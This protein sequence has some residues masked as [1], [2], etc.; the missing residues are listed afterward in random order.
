MPRRSQFL[1]CDSDITLREKSVQVANA[2]RLHDLTRRDRA[3]K[4]WL[5]KSPRLI[6]M[7]EAKD[8]RPTFDF[9]KARIF[10]R[11]VSKKGRRNC[12]L[13]P[14]DNLQQLA[15][16]S[17]WLRENHRK[18]IPPNVW[19]GTKVTCPNE[20][21]RLDQLAR[22]G[23]DDTVRFAVLESLE[24][25]DRLDERLRRLDWLIYRRSSTDEGQLQTEVVKSLINRCRAAGVAFFLDRLGTNLIEDDD[26]LVLKDVTGSDW[27]QWPPYL[28][29]R[30][31]PEPSERPFQE[32]T[33]R[34]K[35]KSSRTAI[36]P[37]RKDVKPSAIKIEA[38][39]TIEKTSSEAAKPTTNTQAPTL[40]NG[41]F[42]LLSD[43]KKKET[44]WLWPQRIPL[45]ELTIIEGDPGTNKSSLTIDLAARV[46]TGRPMPG[47]AQGIAG[48]VLLLSAEESLGKT[49][50]QRLEAAGADCSQI[51]VVE[52]S[53][54]ISNDLNDIEEAAISLAAKLVIIDPL[55]AFVGGYA[56]SEQAV[57]QALTPLA[58]FAERANVAVVMIRHLTK[59]G[60]RRAL[61]RGN[62]SIG[63]VAVARSAFLVGKDP[64]DEDMR[65]F[66]HI[67]S[68]LGPLAPAMLFEP[69]THASGGFCIEWRGECDYT[70]DDL[71]GP[72]KPSGV[73]L[74]RAK[75]LLTKLLADGPVEQKVIVEAGAA[76]G[77]SLRTLERSKRILGVVS[78]REGFGAE[79]V[80]FWSLPQPPT[81]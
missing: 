31:I 33:R 76:E 59:S 10:G 41:K 43:V 57:R 69:V 7:G 56:H 35:R 19:I 37:T 50:R 55:S 14:N 2:A 53:L 67:K 54:S 64:D 47:E 77:I 62:G 81:P 3:E 49:V 18:D 9:L 61:Y 5:G 71:L 16:F 22:I 15:E 26:P 11:I 38:T 13:W 73:K 51:V 29:V 8:D 17:A 70:A 28:R 20:L 45:G 32:R 46:S 24:C 42:R 79:G 39:Q 21:E 44:E 80:A 1:W 30:E 34:K 75:A 27:S 23:P 78:I 58:K 66:C 48:R 25:N 12:W 6:W 4:P 63:I 40:P 72:A 65:V 74:E 60:G 36:K 68:N 52:D